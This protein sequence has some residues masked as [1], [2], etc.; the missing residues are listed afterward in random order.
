MLPKSFFRDILKCTHEAVTR[1]LR[2][3]FGLGLFE[4]PYVNEADVTKWNGNPAHKLLSREAAEKGMVLLKNDNKVLPLQ[5]SVKSIALIGNDIMEARLGGYSGPGNGK[6]NILD[7]I[8][9][10]LRK[11]VTINL[12]EGCGRT[13]IE[14]TTVPS[15]NLSTVKDGKKVNGLSAEYFNNVKLEG[16]PALAR[17]DHVIDFNWTLYSPGQEVINYDYYSVK[18]LGKIKAPATGN[19]KIGFEGNDGYRLYLNGKLIIDNWKSQTYSTEL[20]DFSFEKDKEYDIKIEFFESQGYSRLKL[21]WNIGVKNDWQEKIDEAVAAAKKSDV[22]VIA[23]GIEE[24]EF[25]DRAYLGLLGHQEEMINAVAATG[26]PVVV[27]LV[28]GSA[29]TMNKWINNV[30]AILDIWYPGEDGGHAVANILF[31]DANPAGR[32]PISFPVF[33]GQLPL[34][35]NHKPTGRS[36]DYTNLNGAPLFP[37]GYGLSYSTFEYSNLKFDKKRLGKSENTKVYCTIKNTSKVDGDEVVQLY[38][39]DL[40]SSIAQ[41]NKQLKGFQRISLQSGESKEISFDI[42]KET[43]QM[44]NENMKWVVEPGDFRIMIGPSS[45][46][47]RLRDVISVVE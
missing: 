35:Y 23:A 7:G 27:L 26:K 40:L 13:S 16:K 37:F 15:E 41:P 2:V 44:L 39:R 11:T 30:P 8:K 42:T 32:L 29:I 25:N 6:V 12:A 20:A 38:V 46:D 5:K 34:V 1:V 28:G 9:A 17:L 43:L 47:I 4:N 22:A 14:Y 19:Y 33:E 45:R 21:V 36:D 10:K 24:G 3:K 31:G 18:W